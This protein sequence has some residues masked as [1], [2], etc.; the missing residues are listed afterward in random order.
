MRHHNANRKFGLERN[1]RA[2][3]IR[4]LANALILHGKIETTVA[5]AKEIRP[6]VE[7]LVTKGK[8]DSV[9]SRRLVSQRLGGAPRS[10]SKLFTDIAPRYK[11]RAGGYTRITR[12]GRGKTDARELAQIEFV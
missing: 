3:F 7:K 11:N 8:T 9:A 2:A 5:R 6:F 10:V 4:S 12:V 1:A